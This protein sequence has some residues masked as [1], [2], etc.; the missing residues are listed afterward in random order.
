VRGSKTGRLKNQIHNGLA[1][2]SECQQSGRLAEAEALCRQVLNLDPLRVGALCLLGSVLR[3]QGNVA[4]AL[5]SYLKALQ[6]N[7]QSASTHH[8]VGGVLTILNRFEEA[9]AFLRRAIALQPQFPDAFLSLGDLYF[10]WAHLEDA[11][12]CLNQALAQNAQ[13]RPATE[14]LKTIEREN[15]EL[16]VLAAEIHRV[17]Q[18]QTRDVSVIQ[19]AAPQL[20]RRELLPHLLNQLGLTGAGTE[21]G[22]QRGNFSE[23]LLRQWRGGLLYSV[24]P[25]REFRAADYAD[26]AN[27]SQ[28]HHDEFYRTAIQRLMPFQHRSVIWRMTSK[29]ASGLVRDQALDFCYLDGDHSLQGVREDIRL[30]YPKI[31]AGGIL[32]GHD[33]IPDGA[34]AV[35]VFGVRSAVREFVEAS[36]LRLFISAEPDSEFPSWFVL[37]PQAQ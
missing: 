5:Q 33:Y 8:D 23:L 6:A 19:M 29:E 32:G 35:G 37:K 3:Q 21:I 20:P 12:N 27:V 36:R 25:W 2:A 16:E 31:K 11:V 17:R 34:H 1:R 7:P 14:R 15:R 13:L 26:V 9:A 4:A 24:D 22:V 30:W 28:A 18:A 10:R